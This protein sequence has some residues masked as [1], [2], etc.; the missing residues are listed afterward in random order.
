M[1]ALVGPLYCYVGKCKLAWRKIHLK[2]VTAQ[3]TISSVT[4]RVVIYIF[5]EDK[6]VFRPRRVLYNLNWF[7][8]PLLHCILVRLP[9]YP[10]V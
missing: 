2:L 4:F 1:R 9:L 3:I 10:P 7:V 8:R 6:Y 5:E